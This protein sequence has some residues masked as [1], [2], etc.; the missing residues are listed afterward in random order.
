MHRPQHWY[1]KLSL[2]LNRIALFGAELFLLLLMFVTVYAVVAR[3]VFRS[4]SIFAMEISTYMLLVVAWCAVGW[5]H[6]ENR[7]VGMEALTVRLSLR[8]RRWADKLSQVVILIFCGI[9][10]WSGSKV[11]VTALVRNYRSGSLLKFP[12]WVAYLAIPVGAILLGLIAF[13]R[14]RRPHPAITQPEEG[15]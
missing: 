3:Y 2:H 14:L 9:L 13:W 8:G 11:V 7:H 12:L 1:G 6:L 4:P 5:V 15:D 10:L